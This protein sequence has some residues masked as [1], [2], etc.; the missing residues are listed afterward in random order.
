M[1]NLPA[2]QVVYWAVII[3]GIALAV[4]WIVLPFVVWSMRDTTKEMLTE[5]KHLNNLMASFRHDFRTAA[6]RALGEPKRKREGESAH[7]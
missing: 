3:F 1:N 6:D 4:A 5:I 7:L 2:I